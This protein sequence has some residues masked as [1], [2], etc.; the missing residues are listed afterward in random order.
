MN[1]RAWMDYRLVAGV[2]VILG[3]ACLGALHPAAPAAGQAVAQAG[4][5][6][7]SG[8]TDI[9]TGTAT[10]FT[11]NL[12][13]DPAR[14]AV[15]LWQRDTRHGGLGIHH[16]A[17]GGMNVAG[18]RHG[19]HWQN[20][21]DSSITVIR[22][23]D[24]VATA[25]VRLRVW[26][27]DPPLYDS[28]WVDISPNQTITLTHNLGGNV[29]DYTVG[30]KFRDINPSGRGIHHFGFGG[31]EAGGVFRGVA[32]HTLTDS[33]IQV[34]RLPGDTSADQVRVFITRPDPPDF[35]S[36][37]VD[38]AQGQQQSIV[39]NLGGNPNGYVVRAS[40]RALNG[41]GAGINVI[42]A[43]GLE[44]G[45]QFQ[46]A[47]WEKLTGS[48]I[49][50][51]RRPQ[52]IY[53]D[54]VR[55]R[56]WRPEV[57]PAGPWQSWTNANYVRCLALVDGVLWAGTE[58]GAVRWN[59]TT[60][61]YH[62]YLAPDGLEDGYVRAIAPDASGVTWFGT[63]DGG[64]VAYDSGAWTA[65]TT[66]DGLANSYVYAL[67]L[68]GGLKWV[69]TGYG[70]NA[71]DDGGTPASKSDDTWTTFRTADGLSNTSVYAVALDS[72]GRKW[73][74]AYGGVSV[75]DDQGTPHD[76]ADDVWATFSEEDGLVYRGVYALVV[77]QQ[78]RVWA[79]TTSGL[80][81]L[82]F[83]GTPFDKSDDAWTTFAPDDGLTDDD[84]YGLTVD[85][86]SRVWIATYGGG[87][88]VLDHAGTPFDKSDDTWTQFTTSDGLV[89]NYVY[90]VALD[91]PAG[92]VWAGSWGYGLSRLDNAGTVEEKSDDTWTTFATDDPLPDNHVY[93]VLPEGDHTW[94]GTYCGGLSV[95]DGE[96]WTTFTSADGLAS[97]CVYAM[98][99]QEGP[100]WVGTSGGLSAF[101]DAGTPYHS[102]DDTWASF[103]TD[104]GL[105]TDSVY[106]LDF[107][108]AGRLW[109][110]S[111]P[112]GTGSEYVDGGL[113]VLDDGGTPFDKGDDTWMTYVPADSGGAFNAWVYDI[114]PDGPARVWAATY[115]WWTGSEYEGG[116]L[117]L[118]DDA[119][120]PFDKADDT[121]TVFT[122][123]HGLASDW[124]YSVAVDGDGR[125]WAGTSS[126][127]NVLDH[128]GTPFDTAD[129]TWT[130]FNV[131]DGLAGNGV[132]DIF[133]DASGRLWLA[134]NGG[135]SV[136]DHAGTPFDKSD[137]EWHTWTVEDGLVDSYVLTVALGPSGAVWASADTGLSRMRGATQRRLYLP[138]ILREAD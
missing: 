76:K 36:G 73:I 35:D 90:A 83:A 45:G 98:T 95:T 69:G 96:T 112:R 99:R 34:N 6:W 32:W 26:I 19:V 56:I 18:Q 79:G 128:A 74:G 58:G 109:M 50:V 30:I 111:R 49:T 137:D 71:F 88:F 23:P 86:Q 66:S 124:V 42:A 40:V 115:P 118:L 60:G 136:L 65:F 82:D 53:A 104:D 4:T 61:T 92:Q 116:G 37:W 78:D 91:E 129:D 20:L 107:D 2:L 114:A 89:N 110:G 59:P 102:E 8:W 46:G 103:R 135:V 57:Q 5:F 52:D 106:D 29:D 122:T 11:H 33:T 54:Q 22:W 75:L 38:V 70:L 43:G 125:V 15:D 123:T 94:V 77:D 81:V 63:S 41:E 39:H 80:S 28:G 119:G 27:P 31:F 1:R 93:A 85:S 113:S 24:D 7:D 55:I 9:A 97:N 13:G 84:V 132:Q 133:F 68:Q 17:Y 131:S 121:W 108:V 134:T 16:R 127:L 25:Q 62:K 12:G 101:D 51:F 64:L 100:R 44:V 138:L 117:V 105:N 10:V 87:I 14:Y 47:N 72:G 126:G 48:S 21:T 67:A 120:T 3:L 130:L